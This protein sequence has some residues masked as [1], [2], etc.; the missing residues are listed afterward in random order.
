MPVNNVWATIG[1]VLTAVAVIV[2]QALVDF[3]RTGA[4]FPTTLDGW[5]VALAPGVAAGLL[6]LLTPHYSISE[7]KTGSRVMRAGR[8]AQVVVLPRIRGES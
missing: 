2:L 8:D 3:F 1:A 5:V 4:A 6:A 7:Q